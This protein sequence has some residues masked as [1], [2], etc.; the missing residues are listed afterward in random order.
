M[1]KRKKKIVVPAAPNKWETLYHL[2]GQ[3]TGAAIADSW[4]GGGD[5]EDMEIIEIRLK[6]ADAEL[7][8][9]IDIMKRDDGTV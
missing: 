9:H 6:L 2:I 3:Y 8:H 1:K 7:R 5:P 4:K